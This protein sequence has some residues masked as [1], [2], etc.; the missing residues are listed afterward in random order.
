MMYGHYNVSNIDSATKIPPTLGLCRAVGT[1]I[2]LPGL[3][4]KVHLRPRVPPPVAFA[5]LRARDAELVADD[6]RPQAAEE[7][8]A[9]QASPRSGPRA[10]WPP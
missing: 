9:G 1:N 7:A 4:S 10:V 2:A 5:R 3:D 6:K 8:R